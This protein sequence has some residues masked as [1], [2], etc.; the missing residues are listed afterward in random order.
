[1]EKLGATFD[2]TTKG[3][4]DKVKTPFYRRSQD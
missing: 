2:R 3:M 4:N 1:M